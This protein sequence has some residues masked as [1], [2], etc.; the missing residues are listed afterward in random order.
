MEP[1]FIA[2]PSIGKVLVANKL[3]YAERLLQQIE[4]A[5]KLTVKSTRIITIAG[6]QGYE[7]L[8][9]AEDTETGTPFIIYQVI[10]FNQD[11][12][13]RMLGLTKVELRD[14]YLPEF[15]AMAHSLQKR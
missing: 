7:S 13:I 12:Y 15:K 4:S 5:K 1:M 14:E 6:L 11:S 2:V 9:E 10:L 8:A 3:Q